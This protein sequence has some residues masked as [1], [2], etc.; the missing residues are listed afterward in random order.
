MG[1]GHLHGKCLDAFVAMS[2]SHSESHCDLSQFKLEEE[3]AMGKL[4]IIYRKLSELKL[5]ASNARTHS[6]KQTNQIAAAIE[7]F[8]FT[9]PVLVDKDGQIIAGHG[10]VKA[11]KQLGL[12]EIPTIEIGHLTRAQ[13][14]ALRLADNRLAENAG[15][16]MEILVLE[17]QD[18]QAE[19]YEVV[20]SGFTAPQ[21]DVIFDA[22]AATKSDRHDDDNIP[23]PGP[24]VSRAG[25]LWSLGS[26]RLLCGNALEGACYVRLLDGGKASLVFTDPPYNVAIDG[27]VAN[28]GGKGQVQYRNFAMGNG[29][30]SPAAFTAFLTRAYEY[31]VAN[32]L[33]G[34]IHFLCMD[35]RHMQEMLA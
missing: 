31:L 20:L 23:P 8:G 27:N 28:I 9:N 35:W 2:R 26:H 3:F 16:D 18:L 19:G 34:S 29:E 22:A 32:S 6:R 17:L 24:A 15:W 21:I 14:R 25:D 5:Y 10:R 13:K 11:A 7:E 33:A 12:T 1:S 30:M 4:S